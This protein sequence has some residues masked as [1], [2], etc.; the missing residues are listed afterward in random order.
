MHSVFD[1]V[2]AAARTRKIR[3]RQLRL[4]L[5]VLVMLVATQVLHKM[6]VIA[7]PWLALDDVYIVA[8]LL[9]FAIL[10]GTLVNWRCPACQKNLWRWF[11]PFYCPGCGI[12]IRR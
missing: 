5:L 6:V 11:Y 12:R 9:V 2:E 10:A 1:P 7:D 4:L 8:A 3:I